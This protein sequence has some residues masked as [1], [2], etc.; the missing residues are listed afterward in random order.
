MLLKEFNY[1]EYA[2]ALHNDGLIYLTNKNYLNLGYIHI[3]DMPI[4]NELMK[5]LLEYY[6]KW[7]RNNIIKSLREEWQKK[8]PLPL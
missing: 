1:N 3:A 2:L 4:I 7:K 5:D 6:I 8:L